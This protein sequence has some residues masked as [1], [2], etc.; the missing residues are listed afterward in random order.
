MGNQVPKGRLVYFH[1]HGSP[2]AGVYLPSGWNLN[3]ASFHEHGFPIPNDEWAA[4]LERLPSEGLYRV[5]GAFSCCAKNCAQFEPGFLVQLGYNGEG[6]P[7][8]FIPEWTAQGLGIPERGIAI[9]HERLSRLEPLKVAQGSAP[10][11]KPAGGL[12]H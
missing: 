1:N 11:P 4:T 2:G 9:D 6:A 10:Q 3:R 5:T 7:I 8:L 12:L